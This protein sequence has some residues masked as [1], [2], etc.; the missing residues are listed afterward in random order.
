MFAVV[1]LLTVAGGIQTYAGD[2]TLTNKKWT[3]GTLTE[4]ATEQYYKIKITKTGYIKVEYTRDNKSADA[5]FRFCDKNKKV[6][7]DV[8]LFEGNKATGYFAVKKGI[9]YVYIDDSAYYEWDEWEDWEETDSEPSDTLKENYKVRYTFTKMKAGNNKFKKVS[10]KYKKVD[11]I[12]LTNG[13]KK[14]PSSTLLKKKKEVSGL[15]FPTANGV[16]CYKVVLSK[17]QKVK[18]SYELMGP[19]LDGLGVDSP[20]L[21][22]TDAKGRY[23]SFDKKG[24]PETDVDS[25]YWWCGKGSDSVNLDKGTYYFMIE[26]S[27]GNTGYYKLKLK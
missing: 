2:V 24:N 11:G 5:S 7:Y 18:F 27:K 10:F 22:I 9:Y 8:R 13:F 6:L 16:V 25:M 3:K 19:D 4:T 23:L 1:A 14:T 20:W 12:K 17:K 26:A 15:V 21:R